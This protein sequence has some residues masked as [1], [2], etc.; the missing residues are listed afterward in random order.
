M[1]DV[2]VPGKAHLRAGV[3]G[4]LEIRRGSVA[5]GKARREFSV[6]G[7]PVNF[8]RR[9]HSQSG[10]VR[11]ALAFASIAVKP[12]GGWPFSTH[13]SRAFSNSNFALNTPEPW[14][15]PGIM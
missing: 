7:A 6:P 11:F 15:N 3:S 13:A 12:D 4:E 10:R 1:I 9:G 8:G 14:P 2:N 5:A